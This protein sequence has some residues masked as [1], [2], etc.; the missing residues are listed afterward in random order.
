MQK[1]AE[2]INWSSSN[3]VFTQVARDEFATIADAYL[4]AASAAKNMTLVTNE[5]SDPQC[6]KR[7]KIPDACNALNVRY[8]NLN[9][10]FRELG[11]KI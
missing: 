1:Y 6:K 4:V 2:V 3:P 10:V 8:C 9:Q 7:V 5:I 11:I